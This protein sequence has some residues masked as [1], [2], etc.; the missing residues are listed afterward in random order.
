MST[1]K[2]THGP[3]WR[4]LKRNF[5]QLRRG[6]LILLEVIRRDG[7]FLVRAGD[8]TSWQEGARDREANE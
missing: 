5:W 2:R 3:R 6:N 7:V 4:E 1:K 8:E